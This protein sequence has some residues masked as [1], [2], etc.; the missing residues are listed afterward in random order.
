MR[1]LRGN[2]NSFLV[3][4]AED[5]E[6]APT[7]TDKLY[8]GTSFVEALN[9]R[10]E[11]WRTSR[12]DTP[13]YRAAVA[14]RAEGVRTNISFSHLELR[15]M[16]Q[17]P[18]SSSNDYSPRAA[19]VPAGKTTVSSSNDKLPSSVQA[20]QRSFTDA[21]AALA[22]A[23][24][25]LDE[26]R[27]QAEDVRVAEERAAVAEAEAEVEA[28]SAFSDVFE[29]PPLTDKRSGGLI[30][31]ELNAFAVEIAELHL[32]EGGTFEIEPLER[33]LAR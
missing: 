32:A 21:S 13:R 3:E 27:A 22:S 6:R 4:P 16:P 33:L 14:R 29:R 12:L 1:V 28:N 7:E 18:S 26:I 11:R 31:E 2:E 10:D 19:S 15:E 9:Q 25:A 8:D 17:T 20:S 5:D 30:F 23:E 24:M